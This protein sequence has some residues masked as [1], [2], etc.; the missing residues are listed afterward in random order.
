VH[1]LWSWVV[2][3]ITRLTTW[4][5]DTIRYTV[6]IQPMHHECL[7]WNDW[8]YVQYCIHMQGRHARNKFHNHLS[9]IIL[10]LDFSDPILHNMTDIQGYIIPGMYTSVQ[11]ACRCLWSTTIRRLMV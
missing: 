4:S 3:L 8:V 1:L 2:S 9:Q 7:P 11:V 5:M 6:H 10:F